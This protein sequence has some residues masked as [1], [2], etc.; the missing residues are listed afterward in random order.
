MGNKYF[1]PPTWEDTSCYPVLGEIKTV[2]TCKVY[3]TGSCKLSKMGAEALRLHI[4]Y[5]KKERRK[6]GRSEN[7]GLSYHYYLTCFPS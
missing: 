3:Q 1:F 7:D 5:Y 4:V 6:E 2:N